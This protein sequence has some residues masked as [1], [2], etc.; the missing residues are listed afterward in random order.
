MGFSYI[1]VLGTSLIVGTMALGGLSVLRIQSRASQDA[2]VAIRARQEGRTAAELGRFILSNDPNWRTTYDNNG[3]IFTN[4]STGSGTI[5][6]VIG[7]PSDWDLGNHPHHPLRL[8]MTASHGRAVQRFQ[9]D[10]AANPV[11]LDVLRHAVHCWVNLRVNSGA[12]LTAYG[13]PVGINGSL[14]NDNVIDADVN[15]TA[16]S[17][18]GTVTGIVTNAAPILNLPTESVVTKYSGIGTQFTNR[19]NLIEKAVITPT[20]NSFAPLNA[21]GV[22]IVR[23][24][25]NM[26]IRNTR[27]HGTLVVIM[28]NTGTVVTVGEN[29]LI[30]PAVS[31]YPAL[32]VQGNLD[33]SYRS[34]G[35]VLS[36]SVLATNFNPTG[37][38][39]GGS[40]DSDV[41]DRYPSEIQG[42]IYVTRQ[43]R[44]Y[45]NGLLRG[46]IF[47]EGQGITNGIEIYGTPRILYDPYLFHTPA[48]WLTKRLDMLPQLGTWKQI[49]Q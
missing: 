4:R 26:T 8:Q 2:I 1:A 49:V 33:L 46:G 10:L 30:Q 20:R 23:P 45:N 44:W 48:P 31:G 6:A 17:M 29:V 13:A 7:D 43:L 40:A 12:T 14:T 32:V 35:E 3:N 27:I 28:P 47:V 19:V 9:V 42:L 16:I 18:Q 38:P 5:S 24:T 22:Y 25:T 41:A 39:Y 36:E 15:S 21:S 11:A 34:D 37:A